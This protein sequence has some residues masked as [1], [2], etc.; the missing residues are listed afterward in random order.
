LDWRNSKEKDYK[1]SSLINEREG[2][3]S[4]NKHIE[5]IMGEEFLLNENSS[6]R[7]EIL[8]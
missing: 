4:L 2:K 7:F 8:N 1:V 3:N 6:T 5:E